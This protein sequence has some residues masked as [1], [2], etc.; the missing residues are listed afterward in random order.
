MSVKAKAILKGFFGSVESSPI[1]KYCSLIASTISFI[2]G[3][4]DVAVYLDA[5]HYCVKSRGIQDQNSSTVTLSV[6]S[7]SVTTSLNASFSSGAL[8]YAGTATTVTA[9]ETAIKAAWSKKYGT[10]G[11]A[12]A[13]AIATLTGTDDGVIQ[14]SLIHI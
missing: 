6:G 11:T 13:A 10:T 4:P 8:A 3:T 7:N 5:V 1:G 2:T 12:S 14:L 9:I